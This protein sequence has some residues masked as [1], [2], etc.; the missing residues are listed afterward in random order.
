MSG[1]KG[2]GARA[3]HGGLDSP[4]TP[5]PTEA[6]TTRTT[7]DPHHRRPAPPTT[8][9]PHPHRFAIP[10]KIPSRRVSSSA[11]SA[12]RRSGNRR[13][14]V[15]HATR[16]STRANGAPRH[17]DPARFDHPSELRLDRAPNPHLGFGRGAH[18]CLGA[19]MAIRLAG[20]V[21]GTLA[22]DHPGARAVAEPRHRRNLTL[23]GLDRFEVTLRATT[24]ED[25]RT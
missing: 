18:A 20:S 17:H 12:S 19:S 23:R 14:N 4:D 1:R 21:L 13:N 11:G 7:D 22:T 9:N 10:R 16:A 3:Q 24:G 2:E 15:P 6:P 8:R 25:V 5:T